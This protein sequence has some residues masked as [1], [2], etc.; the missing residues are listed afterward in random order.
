MAEH[1]PG[2]SEGQSDCPGEVA[3]LKK[4]IKV[5]M[6]R[7][8]RSTSAQGSDFSLFQ[9]TVM[10]EKQVHKRTAE[11]KAA[12]RDNE[13]INRALLEAT[14]RF[15][16]AFEHAPIGMALVGMDGCWLKVNRAMCAITGY[17]ERRL[18]RM[19]FR[20][21]THPDD[22]EQ[23]LDGLMGL[24]TG[25]I[26]QTEKRYLHADGHVIWVELSC[27]VVC[28][29]HGKPQHFITQTQDITEPKKLRE[30]LQQA[31]RLETVGALA[32]GV[33]HDFNNLLAV[34]LDYI[35]FVRDELPPGS[36]GLSD[37]DAIACAAERGARLT[38]QLLTFGQRKTVEAE[39]LDVGEVIAGMRALLDRPLGSQIEL[40]YEPEPDLWPVEAARA[41]LEQ[42]VLNLVV[43]ARD[44]VSNQ[45]R[46]TVSTEN[47]EL[48]DDGGFE[49]DVASGRYVRVSVADD[50][51]GIDPDT[52]AHVW[53]PFFTTKAPGDGSG[54]GLATVYGIARQAGGGV[55]ISS[56]PRS[57]TRVDVYMPVSER[58]FPTRREL[59]AAPEPS[60]S[61][62]DIMLVEDESAL[63][64][65]VRGILARAGYTVLVAKSGEQALEI[66]AVPG[67]NCRLLVTGVIMPGIW[68]EELAARARQLVAELEVLFVSGH[69]ERSLRRGRAPAPAPMLT[70]PF[71]EEVLLSEVAK[72][73]RTRAASTQPS[74]PSDENLSRNYPPIAAGDLA[75]RR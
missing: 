66:L 23:S 54:L 38:E 19:S 56:T 20:D 16:R 12:L 65:S 29:E 39:M 36:Q 49:L 37:V 74:R 28:D 58:C 60:L 70:K 22:L 46:I 75:Q 14:Q 69:A 3:R 8:E 30:R 4:I 5:L 1:A 13:K 44:A 55:A 62:A 32:G 52:L 6:D 73:I 40:S 41:N 18:L 24:Q 10:L 53:E 43:N 57:G 47:V 17:P 2:V 72:L 25:Q 48:T 42:I 33:A 21:I 31:Q 61:S 34:I 26:Y 64:D 51:C 9:T 67:C 63:R 59:P 68:G 35:G 71:S 45:G 27:S 15:E 50:G 7:A 11:L